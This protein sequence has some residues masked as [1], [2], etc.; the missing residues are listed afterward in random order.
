MSFKKDILRDLSEIKATQAEQHVTLKE[1]IRRTEVLEKTLSPTRIIAA[2]S[3]IG[4]ILEGLHRM[5]K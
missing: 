1:H 5:F 2:M 4:A 3:A